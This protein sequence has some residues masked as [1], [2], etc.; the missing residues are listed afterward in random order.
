[1]TSKNR[2]KHNRYMALSLAWDFVPPSLI[3]MILM[4]LV[5]LIATGPI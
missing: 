1:M 2:A 4:K 5:S 3:T